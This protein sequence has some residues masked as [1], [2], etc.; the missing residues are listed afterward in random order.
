MFVWS[1][2]N[3]KCKDLWAFCQDADVK[4][5]YKACESLAKETLASSGLQIN[6]T[7]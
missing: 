1:G 4:P 5:T 6:S 7:T 2:E 3:R